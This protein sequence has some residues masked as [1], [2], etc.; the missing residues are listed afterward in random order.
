M[1][2]HLFTDLRLYL[3]G[4]FIICVRLRASRLASRVAGG[5]NMSRFKSPNNT[6]SAVRW[7]A[8]HLQMVSRAL[9]GAEGGL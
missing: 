3:V 4:S 1:W 5:L 8:I 6:N 2:V 9:L 7:G